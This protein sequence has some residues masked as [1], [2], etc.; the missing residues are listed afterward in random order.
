MSN[1][2]SEEPLPLAEFVQA[3]RGEIVK[4]ATAA[5]KEEI[6]FG[7]GPIDVEFQ[8]IAKREGGPEGKIKFGVL[9]VGVE[10]G[11]GAKFVSERTQKVKLSLKPVRI[12][13]DGSEEE[14]EIFKRKRAPGS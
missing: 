14:V 5:G 12:A 10:A 6:H 13:L 8:V 11:G 3:L 2:R 4:A 1:K 9:G 7:V